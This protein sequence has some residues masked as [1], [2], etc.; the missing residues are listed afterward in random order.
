[1]QKSLEFFKYRYPVPVLLLQYL[2]RYRYRHKE[3]RGI[4]IWSFH[5]VR[6]LIPTQQ[7]SFYRHA[8]QESHTPAVLFQ[9]PAVQ[10]NAPA[11]VLVPGA[12][13][14]SRDGASPRTCDLSRGTPRIRNAIPGTG[15]RNKPTSLQRSTGLPV[16][17]V[18]RNR[19]R[20]CA[21]MWENTLYHYSG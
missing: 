2:C 8:K 19:H 12:V 14:L 20:L 15:Y 13:K 9:V 17:V 16:P 1:V 10:L 5:L 21:C 6:S 18:L 3:S 11:A 7:Q 4:A